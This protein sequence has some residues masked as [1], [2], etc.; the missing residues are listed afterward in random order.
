MVID[1]SRASSNL[2]APSVSYSDNYLDQKTNWYQISSN[3][4]DCIQGCRWYEGVIYVGSDMRVIPWKLVEKLCR[5]AI[6][7]YSLI[8]NAN[9]KTI[10]YND[11]SFLEQ[12]FS[13]GTHGN[14]NVSMSSKNNMLILLAV[15]LSNSPGNFRFPRFI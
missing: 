7:F 2:K 6:A 14:K 3:Y 13:C 4:H 10:S 12:G 11:R 5:K 9:N 15:N 1:L 8:C